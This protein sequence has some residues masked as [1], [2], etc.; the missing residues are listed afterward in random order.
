MK[1]TPLSLLDADITP[2]QARERNPSWFG[3]LVWA[4]LAALGL[5]I[6]LAFLFAPKPMTQAV[7]QVVQA[8]E[9]LVTKNPPKHEAEEE[10]RAEPLTRS[11][12]SPRRA[13]GPDKPESLASN[14][15]KQDLAESRPVVP[16]SNPLRHTD[17]PPGTARARVREL[18]GRPDLTLYSLEKGHVV[19]HFVYVNQAQ[20]YA[21]SVLLVDGGVVSV[22]TGIPSVA[23]TRGSARGAAGVLSK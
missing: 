17:L 14:P 4:G 16:E 23:P 18:L 8:A 19:E 1:G 15:A 13:A 11:R 5:T 9:A 3:L 22:S 6:G 7:R 12:Q 20:T 2:E 10:S 21:T